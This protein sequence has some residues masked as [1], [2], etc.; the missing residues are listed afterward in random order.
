MN[1]I[2]SVEGCERATRAASLCSGHYA[3][4]RSSG[5]VP[6]TPLR[7]L[8]PRAGICDVVACDRAVATAGLCSGHYARSRASGGDPGTTAIYSRVG[9]G[10]C[11]I[12][13]CVRDTCGQGLCRMH[14]ERVRKGRPVGGPSPQRR[15]SGEG[16]LSN[17][18]KVV[19]TAPGSPPR[20]EH[21]VIMERLLGRPLERHES[22][23]HVNGSRSDN[24][25][26]GPL[27]DFRSGNLELWSTA[28]PAGQRVADKVIYAKT[29]L[30]LYEP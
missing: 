10:I 15:K 29:L 24:T 23:H 21:R 26:S 19:T 28:Q 14:Y 27:I 17:G 25:T 22:V 3:R 5:V 2:C 13:G 9:D 7:S 30:T 4:Y 16:S 20:L 6:T 8:R 18:Y 12:E 1:T 11:S